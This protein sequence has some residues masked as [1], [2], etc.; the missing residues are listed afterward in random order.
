MTKLD[1][2]VLL[3]AILAL[4]L[5]TVQ[6]QT[7]SGT[8][9]NSTTNKPATGDEVI[10]IN[11]TNGMEVAATTKVDS[12]GKFSFTLKDSNPGGGPHLIRAVHQGVTY[13]QIA[14]PGTNSV[15]VKV[16]DVSKKVSALSLTGRR[17]A[18]P[19]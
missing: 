1:T 12:T 7:L 19:G 6:A 17:H 10:L 18:F 3:T 13:H 15:D 16:Y 9:T 5:G 2:P 11:L 14:P 4:A 8:V